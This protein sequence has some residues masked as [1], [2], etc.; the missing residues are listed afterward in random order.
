MPVFQ[1]SS[2]TDVAEVGFAVWKNASGQSI[3]TGY[4][5]AI[6]TTANSNTGRE[7]VLPAASN[8]KTFAGVAQADVPDATVGRFIV[9]GYAASVYIYAHGTSVTTAAGEAIGPGPSS[10]GLSSTGLTDNFGP[11]LAMAAI[12]AAVNSPGGYASGW[13]RAC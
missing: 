3:T 13:V 12:G 9:Y 5:A 10:M 2:A 1:Q 6:C 8:L 7:V 11:V 4:A